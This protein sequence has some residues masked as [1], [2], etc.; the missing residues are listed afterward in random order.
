MSSIHLLIPDPALRDAVAE[1]LKIAD[2]GE[3]HMGTPHSPSQD[4]TA[5]IVDEATCDAKALKKL[6]TVRNDKSFI[7]L[8]GAP[9]EGLE[10]GLFT[11]AFA[12]PLRLGHLLARLHFYIE[13]APRLRSA[14]IAIGPYRLDAQHRRLILGEE[15]IRL[16]EKETALLEYLAQSHAPVGREELLA[17]VWGYDARIDTH[18]LETHIYQL[19][20]KLAADRS[21]EDL[22]VNEGGLYRLGA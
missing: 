1:Q 15:I 16:T 5:I 10:E 13:A 22:I 19:R 12:K 2:L 9:P 8:L 11:E 7:L 3:V 17:A 18:T 14:P 6:Q 4:V 20:R 21:G